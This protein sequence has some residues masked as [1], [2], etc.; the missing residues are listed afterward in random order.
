MFLSQ[1][2]ESSLKSFYKQFTADT[3]LHKVGWQRRL[4]NLVQHHHLYTEVA[5]HAKKY[6]VIN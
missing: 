5:F 2:R 1:K 3:T 4:V 6:L